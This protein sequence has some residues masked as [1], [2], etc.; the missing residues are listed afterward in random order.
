MHPPT[1]TQV[2]V[3][4]LFSHWNGNQGFV[5]HCRQVQDFYRLQCDKTIESCEKHL[6]DIARWEKPKAGMFLWLE[7]LKVKNTKQII[8][9]KARANNVLLVPGQCFMPDDTIS[10]F[11]RIS[12]S[13]E[14]PE[15]I[16]MAIERLAKLLKE[17]EN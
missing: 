3:S 5:E 13:Q 16:D 4:K 9:S 2:L 14:S 15:R 10:N 12:Y 17:A 6:K 7:C 11:C 1:L 8:E